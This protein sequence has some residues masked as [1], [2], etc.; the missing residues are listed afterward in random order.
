MTLILFGT[1]FQVTNELPLF[2]FA[3]ILLT[4]A[5]NQN[6]RRQKILKTLKHLLYAAFSYF[7]FAN[8]HFN[9]F[10]NVSWRV[11]R[12]TG[13]LHLWWARKDFHST[14]LHQWA[15]S[16]S[17][18]VTKGTFP[19]QY[20][21][22]KVYPAKRSKLSTHWQTIW[23]FFKKKQQ[24]QQLLVTVGYSSNCSIVWYSNATH[25]LWWSAHPISYSSSTFFCV[26]SFAIV[27]AA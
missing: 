23:N 4:P 3:H 8:Y 18:D 2:T 13:Q 26:G 7:Q 15:S 14:K 21:L 16:A 12:A 24:Q 10:F 11:R 5:R 17:Y 27:V 19:G 6:N 1:S 9:D 25:E 20:T 22:W